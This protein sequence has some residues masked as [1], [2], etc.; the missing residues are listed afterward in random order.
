[1]P[2]GLT[3][4]PGEIGLVRYVVEFDKDKKLEISINRVKDARKSSSSKS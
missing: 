2:G 1:L 3:I 4:Q